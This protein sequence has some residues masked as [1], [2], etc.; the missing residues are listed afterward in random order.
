MND[1]R[2][3]DLK[4]RTRRFALRV[5]RLCSSLSKAGPADVIGRQLV[6]SGTSVGAQYRE[7]HRAR[8]TAEFVSKLECSIQEL[9]ESIYWMELLVDANFV[10]GEK[11]AP[12][13][14]EANELMAILVASV[15]TAKRNNRR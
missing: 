15:R 8:S 14:S 6:R 2:R 13:V 10:K 4:Q 5:I 1:E 7:A 12:L 3:N 11:L 9:D